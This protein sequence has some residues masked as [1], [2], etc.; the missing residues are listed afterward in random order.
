MVSGLRIAP[1]L[2]WREVKV[3]L[4]GLFLQGVVLCV[5]VDGTCFGAALGAQGQGGPVTQGQWILVLRR[6]RVWFV[7][8]VLL[9]RLNFG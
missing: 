7:N 8:T 1:S 2:P 3:L 4:H 9:L 5:L 6:R